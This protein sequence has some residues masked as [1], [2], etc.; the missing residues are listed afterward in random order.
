MLQ[1]TDLP[2]PPP[3]MSEDTR[4]CVDYIRRQHAVRVHDIVAQNE[5]VARVT[6]ALEVLRA[7]ASDLS[8][9]IDLALAGLVPT[10]VPHTPSDAEFLA[11]LTLAI[12][13]KSLYLPP[14]P[15]ELQGVEVGTHEYCTINPI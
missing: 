5:R 11:A 3:A 2:T 8:S 1:Y 4:Q 6:T 10:P 13:H 14:P 7:G 9:T 15:R 12:K